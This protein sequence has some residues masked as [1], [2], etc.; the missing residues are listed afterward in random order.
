MP[1]SSRIE[2]YMESIF[3]IEISGR[4][5][6]V[7]DLAK[8]LGVAKATVVA[9][10]RRLV[11][12]SMVC[13]E[14]YGALRLTDE[15]RQRA[16]KIYRRHEHLTFLFHDM[17]GFEPGRAM[18]MACALEHEMDEKSDG[19]ILGFVD[20]LSRSRKEGMPWIEELL[21]V[22]GDERKMPRPLSM[23]PAGEEGIVSR[24]TASVPL[25]L[26]LFDMGFVPGA[27]VCRKKG[28]PD[29]GLLFLDVCGSEAGLTR[30]EASSVWV[31]ASKK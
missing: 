17:L 15:G 20:Y 1:V 2:D 13:H 28:G 30:T 19:R 26:K 6:T 18:A 29:A 31:S 23:M 10:V 4:E 21:T 8:T 12:D 11:A 16:L 22:M 14:R 25:R 24:V 7:T 5:A 27:A 3:A 9:A